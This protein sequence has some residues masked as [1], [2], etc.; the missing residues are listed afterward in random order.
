MR[1]T[2]IL[3][4][5][6]NFLLLVQLF[7]LILLC[8]VVSITKPI[9]YAA[10]CT[11]DQIRYSA[12]NNR[13]YISNG[14]VCT[15]TD[16]KT[17]YP[18]AGLDLVDDANKIWLLRSNLHIESGATVNLQGTAIGG[19]VNTLRIQSDTSNKFA[20]IRADW[21]NISID[22]TRITSWDT[23]KN[24]PDTNVSDGRAFIHIRSQLDANDTT[25][26]ESRMDIL[27]S[28]IGYLGYYA[29]ESYGLVWKVAGTN[30]P[31]LY[32]KVNVLGDVIN[33]R[34]HHNYFGA[35]TYGAYGMKWQ[36][37]EIDNNIQY[38]LDPHDDSD[39]LLIEG[40]NAHHNGNHGII[41]SQRCD[42]LTIRNN[43][44]HDNKQTGLMLHRNTNDSLVEGNEFYNNGDSG[45]AIFDS[46]YNV[47]KNNISYNNKNG[48]R[49]S[50]GS[51]HNIVEQNRFSNNKT[52]G[53]YFYKGSDAPTSGTGRPSNNTFNSNTINGNNDFVVKA[54]EADNN[55]FTN[56][57]MQNNTKGV[58]LDNAKNNSFKSNDFTGT[59]TP[60]FTQINGSTG[61][62]F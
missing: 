51:S 37:N 56:N 47:I 25:A 55:S 17:Q 36:N 2:K 60:Y 61:N 46:H 45:I 8:A 58:R 38:G 3:S 4:K 41:C 48:I 12:S 23:S 19:D 33:S 16:I 11:K 31:N 50:V 35:Y 30:I 53:V 9:A 49:F 24:S 34:L 44:S 57:Q 22:S 59:K 26:H 32:D 14:A 42:H 40:N 29:P 28:D 27:N 52:Y 5:K 20:Y 1:Y 6:I 15:L 10:G 54:K 39:S 62:T 43:K 7:T 21:G 18:K 13:L